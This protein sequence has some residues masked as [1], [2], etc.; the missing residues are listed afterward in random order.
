ML[1]FA[2]TARFEVRRQLGAGG[3]GIVYE[4]WDRERRLA[5]ALKTLREIDP[6]SLYRLKNEFRALR[7]LQ[8]PN[9]VTL[10]ELVEDEGHWFYTM[11][12]IQG[13]DFLAWVR[14]DT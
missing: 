8:H 10:G 12:L 1:D 5:V 6:N 7:G 14:E 3:M 11:E 2:G 9:L 4:A 13:V